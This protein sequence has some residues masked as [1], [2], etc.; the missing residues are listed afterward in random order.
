MTVFEALADPTRRDILRR[1]RESGP[2]SV[3]EV[4]EPLPMTRQAATRHLDVLAEAGLVRTRRQGR[5]RLHE[6]DPRPLRDVDRWLAPFAEEWDRR[7][8]RL[9]EHLEGDSATA[10]NSVSNEDE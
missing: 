1:L 5:R 3:S 4:A 6:L 10:A 8:D 2:L 7:L 9:R